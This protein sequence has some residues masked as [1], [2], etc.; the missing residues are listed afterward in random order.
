[1]MLAVHYSPLSISVNSKQP[2]TS[3]I[4]GRGQFTIQERGWGVIHVFKKVRSRLSNR[5]D[6]YEI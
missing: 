4:V 5:F 6:G 3:N 2:Q 1:M